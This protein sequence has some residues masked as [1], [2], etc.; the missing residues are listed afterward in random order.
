ME[1]TAK[2]ILIIEDEKPL[3]DILGDK[4]KN[5]GFVEYKSVTILPTKRENI[6][7]YSI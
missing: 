4:L 3:R 6:L 2:K 5:E 1:K 7:N